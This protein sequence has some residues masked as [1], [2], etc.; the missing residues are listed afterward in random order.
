MRGN[1]GYKSGIYGHYNPDGI[2]VNNTYITNV[3]NI[4]NVVAHPKPNR[5]KRHFKHHDRKH[6][7]IERPP[8]LARFCA[9]GGLL[10][11]DIAASMGG[12]EL[13]SEMSAVGG[14]AARGVVRHVGN[15]I[16]SGRDIGSGLC[17]IGKGI[18]GILKAI[19]LTVDA[20]L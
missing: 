6:E 9:S 14:Y 15:I 11:Y 5:Y 8:K 12:T 3:T 18:G 7:K 19:Y 16:D 13:F 2:V 10:D 17:G 20:I 1:I 4:T